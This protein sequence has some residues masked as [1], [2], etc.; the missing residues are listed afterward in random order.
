[1]TTRLLLCAVLVSALLGCAR[2]TR[3]AVEG[4]VTLDGRPLEKGSIQFSPLP[5]STGPTAG[6]NIVGGKFTILPVG[7]PF[8]GKFRVQITAV[9]LTGRKVLDPRSN[10]MIDEYTQCLP[11]RYNSQS[12]LQAEVAANGS[13]HFDFAIVSEK[14]LLGPK[15]SVQEKRSTR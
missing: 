14:G 10:S 9:G 12:Q 5:G 8:A 4:T 6:A 13:N 3:M 11:A 7:G 1:M 15:P 2:G